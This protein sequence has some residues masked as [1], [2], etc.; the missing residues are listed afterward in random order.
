[1]LTSQNAFLSSTLQKLSQL[2]QCI[3]SFFSPCETMNCSDIFKLFSLV[4]HYY[5]KY[6]EDRDSG[7]IP[8][9]HLPFQPQKFQVLVKPPFYLERKF[10]KY[11][12]F[13]HGTSSKTWIARGYSERNM[14][15][16]GWMTDRPVVTWLPWIMDLHPW[17]HLWYIL[18]NSSSVAL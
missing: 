12:L 2:I 6:H 9:T 11:W 13:S 16:L 10:Q 8:D 4:N 7:Y 15:K 14:E 5:H 17:N 18:K 1:M 3:A